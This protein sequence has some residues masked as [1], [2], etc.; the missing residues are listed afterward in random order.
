[1]HLPSVRF[2]HSAPKTAYQKESPNYKKT[3]TKPAIK[4]KGAKLMPRPEKD[5]RFF[6]KD[7]KSGEGSRIMPD[8]HAF[9][10]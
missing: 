2:A 7:R 1:L 3:K 5:S 10:F 6:L 9:I 8:V 4:V